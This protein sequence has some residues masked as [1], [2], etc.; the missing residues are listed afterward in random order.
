MRRSQRL[1]AQARVELRAAAPGCARW[2]ATGSAPCRPS[3]TRSGCG[4]ARR[5]SRCCSVG[6]SARPSNSTLPVA[7]R[8][9]AG[10][11]ARQRRLARARFADHADRLAAVEL[12]VDVLEDRLGRPALRVHAGRSRPRAAAPASSSVGVVVRRLARCARRR[13]RG[14]QQALRVV[15]CRRGEDLL[16]RVRSRACVPSRSTRMWSAIC[17]T[18]ARS[19]RHVH[20]RGAALAHHAA[21]GAQHLDLRRHVERGGRLVEDHELGVGDQR[22]RRHQPLQLAAGDL[23]RIALRRWSP[24]RAAPAR[25]TAATAFASASA[26]GIR[27]WMHGR[28]DHLVHD[29]ARRIEGRPPRSARCRPR[30]GRAARAAARASSASTSMSP[31]RTLPPRCGSRGAHSPSAP[32]RWWSCP[33]PTRRS[34]PAPR[35]AGCEKL[36]RRRPAWP[37][38]R[39]DDAQLCRRRPVRPSACSSFA[40]RRGPAGCR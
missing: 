15:V 33:S 36:R 16:G 18:T 5:A 12:Q 39:C 30:C 24:D 26:R 34:A 40:G 6:G 7:G 32:A 37:R 27:P 31:M 29:R 14:G 25:G 23:V 11:D 38:R 3:G 35:R 17:A 13:P 4:A 2:S 22:H 9:Q 19:W 8:Q 10:D 28:L 20:R 21:E 1:A